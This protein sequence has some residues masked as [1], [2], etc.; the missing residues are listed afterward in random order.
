MLIRIISLLFLLA[1][2]AHAG[3][4]MVGY[5]HNWTGKSTEYIRLRDVP[6]VYNQIN[7]AFAIPDPKGSGAMV[8]EPKKQPPEEFKRDIAYHQARGTRV[9]LSIGGGNH[10]VVLN[11]RKQGQAF[12]R[13]L[14]DLVERYG[15]NGIDINLEKHSLVLDPGDTDFRR[16]KTPRVVYFIEGI[17]TVVN[18]FD[19]TFVLSASPETQFMTA[20]HKRYGREFGGYLPVLHALRDVLDVVHMQYYNSGTQLVYDGREIN[21]KGLIVT[22]GTPDFVV[23]LTEMLILGFPVG[24]NPKNVFPGLGA[25]KVAI[26]LPATPSA[27]SGGGYLTPAQLQAAMHYLLTG[28]PTYKTAYRLRQ[29]GGHPNLAGLMTWSI[30]WDASRDGGTKPYAFAYEAVRLWQKEFR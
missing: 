12:A 9:L 23:A 1:T 26:G 24:L 7:V 22:K 13:S 14:I 2:S 27:A 16:P 10:P 21:E 19:N 3:P 6:S 30:N 28:K 25:D 20:G 15:F 18:H 8:F 29:K 17:R 5:W 4:L 11:S